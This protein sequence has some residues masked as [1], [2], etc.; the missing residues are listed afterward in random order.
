MGNK[1]P[2]P[3]EPLGAELTRVRGVYPTCAWDEARVRRL[4]N[5]RRLAPCH[6][7]CEDCGGNDA[8]EECPICF[9]FYPLLN[10][11]CCCR[12]AIC[13]GNGSA[14]PFPLPARSLHTGLRLPQSHRHTRGSRPCPRSPFY[15]A[16]HDAPPARRRVLPASR[17]REDRFHGQLPLL[18]GPPPHDHLCRPALGRG[19]LSRARA[20]RGA[21]RGA[22]PDAAELP[23]RADDA[24]CGGRAP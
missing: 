21:R 5:D 22:D 20:S 2:R 16:P 4:I 12:K 9:Y 15:R 7:G 23:E 18:Q 19:G 1:L 3:R 17:P 6:A 13:T 10:R 11:T 24:E 8:L 14:S